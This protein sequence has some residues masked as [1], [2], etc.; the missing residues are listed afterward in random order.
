M[1]R[2]FGKREDGRTF[3]G[4]ARIL[5]PACFVHRPRLCSL[6]RTYEWYIPVYRGILS[7]AEL[8]PCSTLHLSD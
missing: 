3:N 6:I 1:A 8:L 7:R 4:I 5:V 2:R